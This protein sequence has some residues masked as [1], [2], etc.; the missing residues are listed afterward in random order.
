MKKSPTYLHTFYDV[1]KYILLEI[2][3]SVGSLSDKKVFVKLTYPH[4]SHEWLSI[5]VTDYLISISRFATDL[6]ECVL[7][8]E[9]EVLDDGLYIDPTKVNPLM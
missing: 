6:S 8:C 5:Q 7:P 2:T 3:S 9:Y 4:H 1:W